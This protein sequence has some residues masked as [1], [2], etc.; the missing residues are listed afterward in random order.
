MHTIRLFADVARC[1]SFSQAAKLHGI[2]QSAASQRVSHLEKRLGVRLL[3]RSVRPLDLTVAGRVFLEGCDDVLQRYDRLERRI[4]AMRDE[5]SGTVRVAAIYSSGI[6]LLERVRHGFEQDHPRVSVEINYRKPDE[7]HR[8]VLDGAADLGV[9]SYPERFKKVRVIQLRDEIMAVVCAPRHELA[10]RRSVTAPQLSPHTMASFDLDLPV[11]RRIKAYLK[12][13]GGSP[14]ITHRFDNLDTLK[15]AV[16][17]TDS[18]AVLPKRT[19][20]REVAAGTLSIVELL[21]MLTRPIGAIYRARANDDEPLSP[22]VDAF[23]EH[24]VKSAGPEVDVVGAL[25]ATDRELIG[26]Q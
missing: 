26:T 6:E 16:T 19:V 2:T 1:H 18:F 24:L 21:P 4:S 20:I 10:G 3:D 5:P 25:T 23:V 8:M 17:V 11:G 22:A 15:S 7:I 14:R 9:V 12:E 13:H